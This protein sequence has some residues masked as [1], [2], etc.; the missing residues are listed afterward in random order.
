MPTVSGLKEEFAGEVNVIRLDA[1]QK[2]N[3]R[4]QAT[5][6]LRGHPSFV[7]LDGNNNV[8]DRFFGPQEEDT[9]RAAMTAVASE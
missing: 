9:L 4:L 7:V 5:Y 8:T 1:D 6:G 2:S 3:S